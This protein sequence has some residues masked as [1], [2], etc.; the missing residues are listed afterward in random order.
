MPS[1]RRNKWWAI[2]P[3]GFEKPEIRAETSDRHGGPTGFICADVS[4]EGGGLAQKKLKK[5]PDVSEEEHR[6]LSPLLAVGRT[7]Q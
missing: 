6:A 3:E 5:N 4:S 2:G 7:G 1:P